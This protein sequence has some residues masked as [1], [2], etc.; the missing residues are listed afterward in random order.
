M[1]E[2]ITQLIAEELLNPNFEMTRQHLSVMEVVYERGHPNIV[3][4]EIDAFP[5]Q[6]IAYVEVKNKSFYL[7]FVFDTSEAIEIS[8]IDTSPFVGITYMPSSVDLTLEQ[9]TLMTSLN[10]SESICKGDY[11]SNGKFQYNYNALVFNSFQ[12]PGSIKKKLDYL[13]DILETDIDGVMN[14]S[15]QTESADLFVTV[16]YH[17]GNGNF[18]GLYVDKEQINRLSK[19]GLELTF[20]IYAAGTKFINE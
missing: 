4:I 16:V 17:I 10:A 1:K 9:L 7:Q 18:T 8:C 19:M 20:D 3:A 12:G 13:L 5:N 11:F 15:R 14:L 6:V 2:I